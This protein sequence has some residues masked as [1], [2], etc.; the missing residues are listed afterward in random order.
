VSIPSPVSALQATSP[1][2]VSGSLTVT[3]LAIF[4]SDLPSA[5][6]ASASVAVTSALTGPSTRSQISATTSRKSLPDFM[7]R[8]G[9]V[10]T[11]STRPVGISDLISSTSA[12]S[13][14][15]FMSLSFAFEASFPPILPWQS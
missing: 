1:S 10:V 9:L 14:K 6:I 7:T 12:V 2:S 4:A 15:N 11:P 8:L 5:I 13:T 3:L